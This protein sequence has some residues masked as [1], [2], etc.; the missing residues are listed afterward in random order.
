MFTLNE[1]LQALTGSQLSEKNNCFSEAVIDS[2][3][4][5][6]GSL[7]V[8]IAGERVDGH[9]FVRNAFKKALPRR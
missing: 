8:A 6:S 4:V 2:R 9:Q 7:F 1:V 5:I 3:Q